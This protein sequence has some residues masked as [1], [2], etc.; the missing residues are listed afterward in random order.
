MSKELT[1][2]QVAGARISGLRKERQWSR[3]ELARLTGYDPATGKGGLSDTRL[4][5]YE[6]GI[7][8]IGLEEATLLADVF[9][10]SPA[11]IVGF[12]PIRF[13]LTPQERELIQDFRSMPES[14]RE[15]LFRT[16]QVRS[17]SYRSNAAANKS[18]AQWTLS[19][20]PPP[21]QRPFRSLDAASK[22][23]KAGS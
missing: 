15:S 11:Y 12:T 17:L 14:E 1:M 10:V 13:R 9:L 5:N 21:P 19:T 6:R 3:M 2:S 8:Q 7:R 22:T 4:A 20:P 16:V 23:R 18:M